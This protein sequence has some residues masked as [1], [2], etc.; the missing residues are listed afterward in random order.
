MKKHLLN[1]VK[2]LVAIAFVNSL[3]INMTLLASVPFCIVM[4]GL[5]ASVPL[6]LATV[7]LTICNGA[8]L[9]AFKEKVDRK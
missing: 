6:T 2:I 3:C 8:L 5:E 4:E 9:S 1:G 7:A